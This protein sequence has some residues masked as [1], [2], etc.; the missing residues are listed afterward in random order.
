MTTTAF[1][2][3]QSPNFVPIEI[4]VRWFLRVFFQLLRDRNVTEIRT[5]GKRGRDATRRFCQAWKKLEEHAGKHPDVKKLR[6]ALR[7]D[8]ITRQSEGF[9]GA[10][11]IIS[12]SCPLSGGRGFKLPPFPVEESDVPHLNDI[13]RLA[14]DA[15]CKDQLP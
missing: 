4:L 14:A 8:P 6:N 1:Q 11:A 10:L 9:L 2:S 7:P 3:P 12:K 15:Y 5:S 13:A